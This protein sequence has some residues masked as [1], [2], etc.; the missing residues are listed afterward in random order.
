[1]EVTEEED[2]EEEEATEEEDTEEGTGDIEEVEDM[3]E[4]TRD[5]EE[6][7]MDIE[8][9]TEVGPGGVGATEEGIKSCNDANV[10]SLVVCMNVFLTHVA[11]LC[12]HV[13]NVPNKRL[14]KEN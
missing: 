6:E 10:L 12:C 3:E 11:L 8:E 5:T 7:E 2:T 13:E 4:A 9:D 1:M 14:S